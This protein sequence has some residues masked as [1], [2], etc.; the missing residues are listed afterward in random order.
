MHELLRA[1]RRK[2]DAPEPSAKG[3]VPERLPRG[4]LGVRQPT[5]HFR[6]QSALA[7]LQVIR[8]NSA[9]DVKRGNAWFVV[10]D[11]P[12]QD[13]VRILLEIQGYPTLP[14]ARRSLAILGWTPLASRWVA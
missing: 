2:H 5:Q 4:H 11:G 10:Q 1:R 3:N 6:G 7:L 9:S 13:W 14:C 12:S 8:R